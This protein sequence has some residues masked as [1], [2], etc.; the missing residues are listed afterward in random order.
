MSCISLV[1]EVRQP[2]LSARNAFDVVWF[3]ALLP[4]FAVKQTNAPVAL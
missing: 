4:R 1:M 2:L 3:L